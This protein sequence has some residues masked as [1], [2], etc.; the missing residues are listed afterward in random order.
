MLMMKA[1][2]LRPARLVS[3]R[4]LGLDR[5]EAGPAG[6]LR[7]GAMVVAARAREIRIGAPRLAGHRAH[8]A[9]AVQRAR[10]Q[11]RHG[12]AGTSRTAIRTPT[13]RRC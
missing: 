9:H 7:I 2:V 3:L 4:K 6:E 5:I 1:G 12:S 13:C 8:A 10:A 11:R